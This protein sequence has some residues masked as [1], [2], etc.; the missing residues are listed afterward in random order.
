MKQLNKL[1]T[2]MI[3]TSIFFSGCSILDS[4]TKEKTTVINDAEDFEGTIHI[5]CEESIANSEW[6][7]DSLEAFDKLHNKWSVSFDVQSREYTSITDTNTTESLTEETAVTDLYIYDSTVVSYLA[8]RELIAE[9]GGDTLKMIQ[10]DPTPVV[11]SVTYNNGVYAVPYSAET[12]VLYY[13]TSTYE[14]DDVKKLATLLK[15]GKVG[16]DLNNPDIVSSFYLANGMNFSSEVATPVT[17]YLL[18]L[19][20]N[21]NFSSESDVSKLGDGLD[22]IISTNEQYEA[23]HDALGDKNLGIAVLPTF[24][25]NDVDKQMKSFAY[26]TAVC[27]NPNSENIKVAVTLANY[28]GSAECSKDLYKNHGIIGANGTVEIEDD[29]FLA[30][31]LN[32]LNTSSVSRPSVTSSYKNY[33]SAFES[34]G[35]QLLSGSVTVENEEEKTNEMNANMVAAVE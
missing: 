29:L 14:A 25:V 30:T 4:K 12:L 17:E 7:A 16:I 32:A 22:A 19:S 18:T 34:M 21:K 11:N 1:T 9:I 33:Y 15:N 5:V 20:K 23:A 6:L 24:K 2:G 26:E 10:D 28:L 3:V 27:V 35:Q 31:M 8:S 13:D